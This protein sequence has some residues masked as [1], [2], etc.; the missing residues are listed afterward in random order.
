[1]IKI[2]VYNE[3]RLKRSVQNTTVDIRLIT[4]NYHIITSTM[5]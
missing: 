2:I 4:E 3:T 5:C 1:M